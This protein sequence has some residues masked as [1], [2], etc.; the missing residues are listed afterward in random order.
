M[1][2][3]SRYL[4]LRHTID[5]AR[6]ALGRKV[7]FR[8]WERKIGARISNKGVL[9]EEQKDEAIAF[10]KKWAKIST[11]SH[12][13]YTEKLGVFNA[14]NIPDSLYYTKV[15]QYFND[16][17]LAKVVDNKVNYYR[18]FPMVKQPDLVCYRQSGF[19]FDG[20]GRSI[21][22]EGGGMLV[23]AC[24]NCFAKV[25]TESCGGS[26]VSVIR[27]REEFAH[28]LESVADD[29]VVQKPINQ[30]VEL[31][32]LNASS[33]NTIRTISMLRKDGSVKVYSS[34]L[35]MG[36]NGSSVDNA[37]SG[38]ITCGINGDGSLKSV[39]YAN[40]G[41]K[42]LFH[43]DSGVRFEEIKVPSFDKIMMLVERLHWCVPQ[44][45]LVSWDFAVG[46]DNEPIL[47]EANL[48][49]GELDFHQLNN[50]P[51]FG[52]DLPEIMDEVFGKGER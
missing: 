52:D 22:A 46:R 42:F 43:P 3:Y 12:A 5:E 51:L 16:W 18:M 27:S 9:T 29:F 40:S 2:F 20:N 50:G 48:S 45:R 44:F 4:K 6:R 36:R 34:I 7:L 35:R 33:V 49:S 47:I 11:T 30:S 15:D 17:E 1:G 8:F 32:R 41:E 19:W 23:S 24:G 21:T 13:Y 39:A 10:W 26:G 28:F 38:G 25:A 31:E 14:A 37:S